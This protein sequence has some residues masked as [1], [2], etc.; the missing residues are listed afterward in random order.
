MVIRGG[1]EVF[2][3]SHVLDFF[4]EKL[5]QNITLDGFSPSLP[6]DKGLVRVTI[7]ISIVK[8]GKFR[9][10]MPSSSSIYTPVQNIYLLFLAA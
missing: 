6:I 4:Y 7:T 1:A 5:T 10:M 3:L 2:Y 9:I 8:L